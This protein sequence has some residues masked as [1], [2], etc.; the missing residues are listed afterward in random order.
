[1]KKSPTRFAGFASLPTAA[2]EEAVSELDRRGPAA[3]FQRRAHQWAHARCYLDDKFFWP[4]LECAEA[5]NVPIYLHPAVPPKSV[6]DAMYGGFSPTESG[7]FA[8]ASWGWRIE[9]AI[10]L[11][12]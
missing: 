1:L 12:R 2:S 7:V 9:T 6:A 10:H 5:L 11:I 8:A 3:E 4:I